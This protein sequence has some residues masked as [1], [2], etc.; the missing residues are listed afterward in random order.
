MGFFK[1]TLNELYEIIK[2]YIDEGCAN[3]VVLINL[4]ERSVGARAG[5]GIK[6]IYDGIDWEHNQFRIEPEEKLCRLGRSKDDALAL[7]P[8]KF[9][10]SRTSY[11]CPSCDG[12]VSKNDRYCRYCGQKVFYDQNKPVIE[13]GV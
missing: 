9:H 4:C 7:V 6:Y 2:S 1:M 13:F 10:S 3:E 5:C 8:I 11:N 12:I